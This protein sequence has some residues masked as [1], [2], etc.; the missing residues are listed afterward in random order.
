MMFL[1]VNRSG[2]RIRREIFRVQVRLVDLH[3]VDVEPAVLDVDLL[4]GQPDH[5]FNV[6]LRRVVRVQQHD[7]VASF[8]RLFVADPF[9]QRVDELVDEDAILVVELGH[10]ALSFDPHRLYDE[11]YDQDGD[12]AGEDHV[13]QQRTQFAPQITRIG[14]GDPCG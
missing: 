6:R 7:D 13:A 1:D 14:A 5:A 8:Y 2:H 12:H 9:A 10:H 11:T 4:A 3:A